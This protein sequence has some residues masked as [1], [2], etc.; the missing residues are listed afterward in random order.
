MPFR[1]ER[2]PSSPVYL[3]V[4][5]ADTPLPVA[6]EATTEA[7]E[8]DVIDRVDRLAGAVQFVDEN[9]VPYGAKQVDGKQRVSAQPYL[10]DIA[11]G[12]VLGHETWIKLGY[13]PNIGT[14]EEDLWVSGGVYV[15]PLAEQQMS[16]VS[17][18]IADDG[19]PPGLGAHEVTI[20]YLD[21]A[22]VEHTTVVIM[23]GTTPVLTSVSD[24][25]RV[26]SF[27]ITAA[28]A[29]AGAVGT[30]T[31]K[32]LAETITYASIA[33]GYNRGRNSCYAVPV[34]KVLYVTSVMIS[35]YGATKGIR[36]TLRTTYDEQ[37]D[38]VRDFFIPHL[39]T[40]MTNGAFFMPLLVPERLPAGGRIKISAIADQAGAVCS[41]S[42]NGWMEIS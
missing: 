33:I 26:N 23:D 12:N 6:V 25:F 35:V 30:I 11:E 16:A 3:D 7:A 4:Q 37:A 21:D 34:G 40:N 42:M 28:G 18:S 36:Y 22:F 13:N 14:T 32:N 24:I 8:V 31:L 19:N 29:T 38:I 9:G 10:Y 39:E 5:P 1:R 27:R 15:W 2:G 17:T 41:C 20:Y